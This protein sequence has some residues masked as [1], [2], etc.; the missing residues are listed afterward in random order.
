MYQDKEPFPYND[1]DTAI[2]LSASGKASG[3]VADEIMPYA[4]VDNRKYNWRNHDFG[5]E[6]QVVDDVVSDKGQLNEVEY[7]GTKE[8]GQVVDRGLKHTYTREEVQE[9][10]GTRALGNRVLKLTNTVLRNREKR[11]MEVVKNT[12]NSKTELIENLTA[13][14]RI[15]DA[16]IKSIDIIE[17]MRLRMLFPANTLIASELVISKIRRSADVI[18]AYNGTLGED[19]MV[20]LAWLASY[21]N[22]AK[23]VV[24]QAKSNTSPKGLTA[25]IDRVWTNDFLSLAYINPNASTQSLVE[26]V[27]FGL[28][29]RWHGPG[30]Q[31]GGRVAGRK[32]VDKGLY[33]A[34]EIRSGESVKEQVLCK[35]CLAII[36]DPV[37]LT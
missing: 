25:Q 11:V 5:D 8:T 2:A 33:G 32:M 9:M 23:I 24:G 7:S 27:T 37:D 15:G 30:V 17:D 16:G 29:A 19:G 26:D 22:V 10:G 3:F 21:Y 12:D 34:W 35:D 20:S 4:R 6:L 36:N 18:K 1:Q 28:T 13:G 14:N 31:R